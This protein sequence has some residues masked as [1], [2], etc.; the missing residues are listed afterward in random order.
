[1]VAYGVSQLS[2]EFLSVA[3]WAYTVYGASITPALVAT[4][5]WKRATCAGAA[6]SIATGTAVTIA[7][8]LAARRG[9]FEATA[10][11]EVDAVIPAI[12]AS[13]AALVLVS[14]GT[15]KPER[16]RWEPFVGAE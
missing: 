2:D 15:P 3:L 9:M 12:V 14:L 6:A 10:W 5:F 16:E 1:M 8:S 4:F 11:A 13:V 7:W